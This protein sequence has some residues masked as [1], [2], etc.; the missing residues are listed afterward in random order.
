MHIE[1][2]EAAFSGKASMNTEAIRDLAAAGFTIVLD[3]FGSG[4][5]ALSHLRD[6][7]LRVVKIDRKLTSQMTETGPEQSI[8]AAVSRL[9]EGLGLQVIAEGIE[10][11]EQLAAIRDIGVDH[12]QGWHF[13]PAISLA[14]LLKLIESPGPAFAQTVAIATVNA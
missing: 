7:H 8:A 1:I 4:F 12:A 9:A 2:T 6:L 13:S 14:E 11:P 3:N 10:S 5:S